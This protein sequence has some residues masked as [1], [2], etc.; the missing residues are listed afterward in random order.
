LNQGTLAD[1]I[2]A[3][4]QD[5]DYDLP[6]PAG[7]GIMN[8]Y[9]ASADIREICHTFYS[10]FYRDNNPRR[11]ILGINPG[12][13]GSGATGLPFTDTK[14]LNQNCD[15]AYD[16]FVTHEPSSAF[17]YQM[18]NAY[19]GPEKFYSDFYINSVCPLGFVKIDGNK[20]I[21]YNYYDDKALVLSTLAFIKWN[22]TQQIQISGRHDVCFVFG[23]GKNFAFLDKLNREMKYFDK[24]IQGQKNRPIHRKLSRSIYQA[25]IINTH[26][27]I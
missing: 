12:R 3:F 4:C 18:I 20:T 8:P 9:R 27:T 15:I 2:L 5:L 26:D 24:V 23:T 14:R 13:L 17:V 21:N 22:I 10:K 7:I 11:L 16:K 19:G 6:L 1:Q 25:S